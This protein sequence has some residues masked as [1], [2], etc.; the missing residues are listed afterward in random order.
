MK[1]C[2]WEGPGRHLNMVWGA[3][4]RLVAALGRFWAISSA[5]K[6]ELLQSI[7]PKWAP[8]GLLEGF[9]IHL[10]TDLERIWEG[11]EGIFLHF[12]MHAK[13]I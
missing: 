11:V 4:R 2:L 1:K 13:R 7:G 6:P 9:G 3:L 12:W 10:G 8:R 5:F